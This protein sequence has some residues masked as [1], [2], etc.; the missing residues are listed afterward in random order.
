MAASWKPQVQVVNEG[1]VWHDNALRFRTKAE[2]YQSAGD[3]A[4]R[5]LAVTDWQAT[6]SDDEPNYQIIDNVQTHI[7]TTKE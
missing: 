4:N 6:E 2:A 3:L 7:V 5:W 1:G